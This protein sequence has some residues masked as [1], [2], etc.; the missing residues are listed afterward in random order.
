MALY[1]KAVNLFIITKSAQFGHSKIS[2]KKMHY[3]YEYY[4]LIFFLLIWSGP[5]NKAMRGGGRSFLVY[6]EKK[7]TVKKK[8]ER[9]LASLLTGLVSLCCLPSGL[10]SRGR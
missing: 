3:I 9:E 7:I 10:I 2:K 8:R 6:I 5:F 1:L 4:S